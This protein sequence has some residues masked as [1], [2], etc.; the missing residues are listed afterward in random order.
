M[1]TDEVQA[2]LK[3]EDIEKAV[4]DQRLLSEKVFA[5]NATPSLVINGTLHS[6]SMTFEE[7]KAVI[8][9]LLAKA[10]GTK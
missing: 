8:D 2:C 9:P 1:S 4:L 10:T 7:F 6:G 5:I 3:K